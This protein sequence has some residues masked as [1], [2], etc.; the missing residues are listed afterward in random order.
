MFRM[1]CVGCFAVSA[2]LLAGC[3]KKSTPTE[4]K[5][6]NEGHHHDEKTTQDVTLPDGKLVH[7]ILT[8]HLD[9]KAGNELDV[10]I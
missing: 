10:I 9:E 8:A 6:K 2:A 7:A 4:F 3:E 5:G 1:I